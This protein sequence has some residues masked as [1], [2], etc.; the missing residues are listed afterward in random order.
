MGFIKNEFILICIKA[1][2]SSESKTS[3]LI[4]S[5]IHLRRNEASRKMS[6]GVQHSPIAHIYSIDGKEYVC[7]SVSSNVDWKK[8]Y[9]F[10]D[11]ECLASG[12][13]K[14]VRKIMNFSDPALIG[15]L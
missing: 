10:E 8:D 14:Y 3:Y 13:C 4:F 6:V 11:A 15:L 1:V 5:E 12:N 9:K 7:T 2:M